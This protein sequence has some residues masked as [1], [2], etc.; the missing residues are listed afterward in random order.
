[1]EAP[2]LLLTLAPVLWGGQERSVKQVGVVQYIHLRRYSLDH[3]DVT[4]VSQSVPTGAITTCVL[5]YQ[6]QLLTVAILVLL[7]MVNAL[8]PVQ[9][10]TL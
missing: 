2:A 6:L 10:T 8:S 7:Q 5:L 3:L 9:P 1:M 4:C